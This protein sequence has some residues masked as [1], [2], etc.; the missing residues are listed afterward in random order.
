MDK[1]SWP[2]NVLVH[3]MWEE[4]VDV[5]VNMG[6]LFLLASGLLFSA[7]AALS[8]LGSYSKKLSSLRL[9]PKKASVATG[10]HGCADIVPL[11]DKNLIRRSTIVRRPP[12]LSIGNGVLKRTNR[13][14]SARALTS[15]WGCYARRFV[16]DVIADTTGPTGA[17]AKTN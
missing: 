6:L 3:Y 16:K 13:E 10:P 17:G 12:W 7:A 8:S 4:E 11:R 9:P 14:H 1:D 15:G 5:D 2:K